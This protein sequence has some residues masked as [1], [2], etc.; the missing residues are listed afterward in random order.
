[1]NTN[2]YTSNTIRASKRFCLIVL[3]DNNCQ[4]IARY[5]QYL[6]CYS[7]NSRLIAKISKKC[8]QIPFATPQLRTKCTGCPIEYTREYTLIKYSASP[9]QYLWWYSKNGRLMPKI[10]KKRTQIP[11]PIPQMLL[12]RTHGSV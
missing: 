7:Q 12:K 5:E 9:W 4:F 8:T 11:V 3:W 1:M 10:G 2:L 6:W